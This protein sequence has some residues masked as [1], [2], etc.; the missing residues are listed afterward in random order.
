MDTGDQLRMYGVTCKNCGSAVR[1]GK[2]WVPIGAQTSDLR[3]RLRGQYGSVNHD[4]CPV[5][6]AVVQFSLH[7]IR[8]VADSEQPPE[9]AVNP[10]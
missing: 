4:T 1:L 6:N 9:Y 2:I 5:C 7:E 10:A 8:F 3:D